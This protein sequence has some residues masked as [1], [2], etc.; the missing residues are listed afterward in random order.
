MTAA[1]NKNES[2]GRVL[3]A[4]S[5]AFD[6]IMR[7]NGL[8]R[9]NIL[10]DR[11]DSINLSFLTE[12]AR[13]ERGGCAGNIA[14]VLAMLGERPRIV[15][16]V[17][18]DFEGYR[19]ALNA[20][21]VDTSC[22]RVYDK[23]LTACCTICSDNSNNQLTFVSTGA[24]SKARELD[25]SSFATPNTK[26]AIISPDDPVGMNQH[27]EEARKAGIPFIYDPSFQVIAFNGEQLLRDVR[28]AK[29]LIVNDYEFSLFLDKTG[30]TQPQLSELVEL[31]VVTKGGDGSTI[32][33]ASAE[34]L[35]IKP[36]PVAKALDPT[37]AGDAFRGGLIY[38]L[39]HGLPLKTAAQVGS[40]CGAYAVE[41]QG[42][43]NFSF[44]AEEFSKRYESA[45]GEA[46]P[47][48]A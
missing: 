48:M 41:C 12:Q 31:I 28:G 23:E 38:G 20:K 1:Q 9:D 19:E 10:P 42:T 16:T 36:V 29:A 32:Y 37:G 17:G 35:N 39:I 14:N 33:S 40:L 45:F 15:G 25:L 30:L 27:C 22:I 18:Y 8:F 3:V 6:M 44:T 11:L 13:K 4:G 5:I 47:I 43:Q 21:G 7:Y 24:M 2:E 26:L 46:A 34:P